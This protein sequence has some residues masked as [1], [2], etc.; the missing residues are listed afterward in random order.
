[1]A[2]ELFLVRDEIEWLRIEE[3]LTDLATVEEVLEAAMGLKNKKAPGPDGIKAEVVKQFTKVK[4][5]AVTQVINRVLGS[6]VTNAIVSRYFSWIVLIL[7]TPDGK[8]S[9]ELLDFSR[10]INSVQTPVDTSRTKGQQCKRMATFIRCIPGF[11]YCEANDQ[12]TFIYT[13]KPLLNLSPEEEVNN[14]SS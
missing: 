12:R 5:E 13:W 7:P 8:R 2:S 4:T 14:N 11:R 3:G 6:E 9:F 10:P 1:M